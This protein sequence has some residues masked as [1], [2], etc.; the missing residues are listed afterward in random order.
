M[1]I[2][3]AINEK[4]LNTFF[5]GL[6][7][8][9]FGI[10][11]LQYDF[12]AF[13]ILG[14]MTF[15]LIFFTK[16]EYAFYFLLA[17]RSIVDVFY[18]VEAAGDVRITQYMG[19]SV[20]ALSL[21]YFLFSGYNVFRLSVNKVY[22]VFMGLSIIPIFFTQDFITGFGYWLKLL[23]GFLI[24]NITILVVLKME[25][26][27]YK[28]RMNAVCWCIIIAL[29]IPFVLFLRNYLKGIHTELGGYIRYSTQDFGGY[30]N[31]FSYYLLAV[32]PIFLFFYSK[33]VKNSGKV[34]WFIILAIMLFIIYQTYTRNVWI[35]IA[36]LL[37]VWNLVRKN[38]K[39]TV[40][41]LCLIIFMA[42]FNPTV[43][44]RFSDIYVILK[45]GSFF[46][47]D[48][49]LL[50]A[51]IG[52]WQAN[53]DYFLNYSTIIKKLF[54]NGF[55]IQSKIANL[56]LKDS[57][58]EHNNYLTLLMTTGICGLS[59]YSLY[60]FTLFRES[61]KLFRYTKQFYFKCLSVVFISVLF[62]YVIICFFTHMLWKINFQYYFSAFAGLVIAAN[63]LE[64]KNRINA[65]AQNP[66]FEANANE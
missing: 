52:I 18:D 36:V 43:R 66:K 37:L 64:E 1:L 5:V 6:I 47:L 39:I 31:N 28:K 40:P 42:V 32:F 15:L 48:P 20:A 23:Q 54:G 51:R 61:F 9:F 58:P 27:S 19:V 16:I 44:D 4:S 35:G 41:V 26:K 29:L 14:A 2:K 11:I 62:A 60:L 38:F 24:L 46:R 65:D 56:R 45:T 34:L 49:D 63:I 50:S 7:S 53:F 22:G 33:S 57:I 3:S 59:V 30:T 13:A 8:C 10:M 21:C 25:D 55:D 12:K 17:S